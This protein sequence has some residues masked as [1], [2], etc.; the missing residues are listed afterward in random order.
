[1]DE[2]SKTILDVMKRNPGGVSRQ[3]LEL[4]TGKDDRSVRKKIEEL[5]KAHYPIGRGKSG[6]TYGDNEGLRYTIAEMRCKAMN[7][8]NTAAALEK[9][10]TVEGQEQWL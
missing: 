9:C 2:I 5:R 3:Q 1:M 10:L 6:Y 8:L 7:Q 4:A